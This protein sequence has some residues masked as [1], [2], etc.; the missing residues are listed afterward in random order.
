[1]NDSGPGFE[2]RLRAVLTP[3]QY[4]AVGICWVK[5]YSQARAGLILGVAEDSIR[6]RLRRARERAAVLL[7]DDHGVAA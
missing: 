3:A 5:G 1:M 7:A 6:S 2:D 4:D